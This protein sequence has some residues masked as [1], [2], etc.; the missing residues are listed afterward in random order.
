LTQFVPQAGDQCLGTLGA[1][2]KLLIARSQAFELSPQLNTGGT[3]PI[4]GRLRVIP[5]HV[6]LFDEGR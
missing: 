2:H 4:L 5:V 1:P 3:S 6:P